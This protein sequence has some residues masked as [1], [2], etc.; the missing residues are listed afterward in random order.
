M[1]DKPL[2]ICLI[3]GDFPALTETFVTTKALELAARGHAVT[4]IKNM[5]V[6]S[7]NQSHLAQV[8][9]AGIK[10]LSFRIPNSLTGLL[11]SSFAH[12]AV[13][14]SAFSFSTNKFKTAFKNK[15]Q[16]SLL[17]KQHFDII[18]YEFSGLAVNYLQTIKSAKCP[19]VVSCRGTAEKV[20]PVSEPLRK[21]KLKQLFSAVNSIHC[22]SADMAD[23]IIHYGADKAKIFINRPSI[24]PA[25]FKRSTPYSN[26]N[27][28]IEFLT[29]GRFTFQK[30]YLLGLL[31]MKKLKE[32][33]VVFTWKIIGDGPQK[34]E[35]MYHIHALDLKDC[36]ELVGKKNRDEILEVFQK[37]DVFV[38]PSVYEGIANVCLEAMSMELPVI[39]TK[40]GGM[41][42]V[43][44]HTQNGLLCDVYNPY[45]LATLLKIVSEDFTFRKNL[46]INARKTILEKFTLERQVN[47]FEEQYYK[48]QN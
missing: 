48:L 31:G 13:F 12:P 19:V 21:D 15:L 23:T 18:H 27:A 5:D 14:I 1:S 2:H 38:L 47:V 17:K 45:Q 8:Q 11:K 42:E 35:I 40:S 37:T 20:K 22:V 29:I 26:A 16:H 10:I 24:D 33:G 25:I 44:V 43:I 4:V 34:E 41:E 46:G 9:K 6:G 39:A 3:T 30:G 7:F 36:V 32:N 28:K